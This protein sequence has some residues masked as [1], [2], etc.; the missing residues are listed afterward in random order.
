MV[1]RL[2]NKSITIQDGQNQ[3]QDKEK[4]RLRIRTT[5]LK[6]SHMK[7]SSLLGEVR[8]KKMLSEETVVVPFRM[9]YFGIT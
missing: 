1:A 6:Y 9:F 4:K 8:K 3:K 5:F 7:F 2:V